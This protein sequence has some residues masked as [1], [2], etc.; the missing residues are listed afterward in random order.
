[1]LY[2]LSSTIF[3]Y[4]IFLYA[5]CLDPPLTVFIIPF[6]NKN[7]KGYTRKIYCYIFNKVHAVSVKRRK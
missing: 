7:V 6:Y 2:L 5:C 3:I 1:M 4:F